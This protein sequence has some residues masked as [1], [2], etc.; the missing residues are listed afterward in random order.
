MLN[1]IL[2]KYG[3]VML[4]DVMCLNEMNTIQLYYSYSLGIWECLYYVSEK[5]ESQTICSFNMVNH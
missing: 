5:C 1:T 3:H 4:Y 2:W